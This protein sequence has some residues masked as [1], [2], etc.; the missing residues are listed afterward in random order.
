MKHLVGRLCLLLSL[1]CAAPMAHAAEA[2]F[3]GAGNT[4]ATVSVQLCYAVQ[5]QGT[6]TGDIV[7]ERQSPTAATATAFG[8]VRTFTSNFEGQG[9]E[10][11]EAFNYRLRAGPSFSGTANVRINT[12][13]SACRAGDF[14][15]NAAQISGGSSTANQG[16]AAAASGG[17][18]VKITDGVDTA[19]V[20]AGGALEISLSTTDPCQSSGTAKSS[21][22]ISATADAE[23]VAISGSTVIYVCGFSA[24]A[25]G[26]TAP[27]F[28]FVY[29]TG[30]TC[31]T[32]LT[33]LT[34]AYLQSLN[35][36]V[37][38]TPG[39]T[40]FKTPAGN[41]L[42]IDVGGT[43]PDIRGVISYVQN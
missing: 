3:T 14:N 7:L 39:A 43:T 42:C 40:A 12:V 15:I 28:R 36:T 27:S 21:V 33:A 20:T 26:G 6:W 24:N 19:N 13:A 17:W 4:T 5:V 9:A 35:G 25:A 23:L 8:T 2:S 41:A 31:A 34:G 16:T 29:G 18:P 22:A 38:Y 11:G 32:G 1:V 30:A 10:S 37:N